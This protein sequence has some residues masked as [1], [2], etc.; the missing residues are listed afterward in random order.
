MQPGGRAL[1]GR[2]HPSFGPASGSLAGLWHDVSIHLFIG[3][4]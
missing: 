3:N 4:V 1:G 2:V